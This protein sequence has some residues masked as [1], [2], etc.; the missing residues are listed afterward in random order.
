LSKLGYFY[1]MQ[2]MS[3]TCT[4]SGQIK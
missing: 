4:M 2:T 1:Q 3:T